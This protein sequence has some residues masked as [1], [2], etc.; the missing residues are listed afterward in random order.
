MTAG[1]LDL[2]ARAFGPIVV[3][4]RALAPGLRVSW[5]GHTDIGPYRG[6]DVP[7][8]RAAVAV[9]TNSCEPTIKVLFKAG[10]LPRHEV[11]GG[12]CDYVLYDPSR[13]LPSYYLA[14][15]EDMPAPTTYE[16]FDL[17]RLVRS[18]CQVRARDPY[19]SK[20]LEA[21]YQRLR[22]AGIFTRHEVSGFIAICDESW[23][24][25]SEWFRHRAGRHTYAHPKDLAPTSL[26]T[27]EASLRENLKG[28]PRTFLDHK[29]PYVREAPDVAAR[30]RVMSLTEHFDTGALYAMIFAPRE[31]RI[32]ALVRP[33]NAIARVEKI[34]RFHAPDGNWSKSTYQEALTR[35]VVV[36]DILPGDSDYTRCMTV[37]FWRIVVARLHRYRALHDRSGKRGLLNHTP[38]RFRLA[39]PLLH[40]MRNI[41]CAIAA[42]GHVR[43]KEDAHRAFEDLD[44]IFEAAL[45]RAEAMEALGEAKR[46]AESLMAEDHNHLDFSITLPCLDDR[47]LA[48]G[49]LREERFRL[50]RTE[51]AAAS[52][53]SDMERR[54]LARDSSTMR[55]ERYCQPFIVEHLVDND[56]SVTGE[57]W[58]LRL[59]RLGVFICPMRF[60]SR[61]RESRLDEIARLALPGFQPHGTLLLSFEQQ[62]SLISRFAYEIGRSFVPIEEMD[63]AIRFADMALRIVGQSYRRIH[64]VMQLRHDAWKPVDF[65]EFA[66]RYMSQDVWPK[67]APKKDL[68]AVEKVPVTV[69]LDVVRSAEELLALGRHAESS[70]RPTAVPAMRA[71]RWKCGP[72]PYVFSH[73]GRALLPNEVNL[74]LRY[75]LAGWPPF[76]LHD[77]R[78]AEAEDANFDGEPESKI[79]TGLGHSGPAATRIYTSLPP[80]AQKQI[81]ERSHQR[82]ADQLDRRDMLRQL[83]KRNVTE[84]EAAG[85]SETAG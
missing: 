8:R 12:R 77:F 84:R 73:M 42:G 67:V 41:Q 52:V 82:K 70:Q 83:A 7:M 30:R 47:G 19:P 34:M 27:F 31:R 45:N 38:P 65:G 21:V 69:S 3:A 18:S 43:R 62:R 76:T 53:A 60:S 51:A 4:A 50:W 56:E 39:R 9:L 75:L 6:T 80:W 40:E 29:R 81:E 74:F 85:L 14:W 54:G 20:I 78:H 48:V 72:A 32:D 2:Q 17:H 26:A 5:A 63:V 1:R 24:D 64:E 46:H 22:V 58:M 15:V 10:V 55:S 28:L 35:Y 59:A 71:S 66:G 25:L 49:G 13:D 79:Q 68:G 44:D 23:A 16:E 37:R 36:R 11:P 33:L 57:C 61:R